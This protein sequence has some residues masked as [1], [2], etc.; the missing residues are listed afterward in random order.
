MRILY[1]EDN[2]PNVMLVQRVARIGAHD[3]IS[4]PE[5]E[6]AL[7]R[8]EDDKPDLVLMDLQ[9]QG[10]LNGLDVVR[11]LR[12]KGCATPIIALTAYA[13]GGDR[14][15]CIEAGCDDYIPKPVSVTELVTIFNRYQSQFP[16]RRSQ[17]DPAPAPP[18]DSTVISKH[19]AAPAVTETH[20]ALDKPAEPDQQTPPPT[21]GTTE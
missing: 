10:N 19:P 17:S 15:R 8:F 12:S 9:L 4:Y 18:P 16:G 21:G 5:G 1:V 14:Q 3:V 11:I 7:Q 20:A 6:Q 13:M 2:I